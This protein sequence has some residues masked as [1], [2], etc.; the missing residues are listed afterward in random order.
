MAFTWRYETASATTVEPPADLDGAREVHPTQADAESWLGE[1][2]RSLAS[3]GVDQ[4]TLFEDS[5]VVYG[6]MSLHPAE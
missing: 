6:P 1:F 3:A 2:W 5:T 4:V